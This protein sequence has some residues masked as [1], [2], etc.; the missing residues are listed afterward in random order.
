MGRWFKFFFTCFG[1][2]FEDRRDWGA[3]DKW[4]DS[5]VGELRVDIQDN[6]QTEQ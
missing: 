1:G 5:I 2:K 3:M 6:E 4:A